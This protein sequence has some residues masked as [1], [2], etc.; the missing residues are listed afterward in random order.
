MVEADPQL[1]ERAVQTWLELIDP[2]TAKK[3]RFFIDKHAPADRVEMAIDLVNLVGVVT[4]RTRERVGVPWAR[5]MLAW[6]EAQQQ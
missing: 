5:E 2:E 6:I 3:L 1:T 4:A